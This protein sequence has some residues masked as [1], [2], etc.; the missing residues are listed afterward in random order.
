[1]NFMKYV[2]KILICGKPKGDTTPK[3]RHGSTEAWGNLELQQFD[4]IWLFFKPL[5]VYIRSK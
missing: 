3:A 4:I 5:P 1:M 2:D